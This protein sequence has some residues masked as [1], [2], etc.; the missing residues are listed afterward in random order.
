MVIVEDHHQIPSAGVAKTCIDMYLYYGQCPGGK[1]MA[2]GSGTIIGCEDVNGT[3][4][5]TILT[6]ATLLRSSWESNA[7]E[8]D[9][10][11][12]VYLGD[13]KFFEGY[14]SSHDFHFNIATINV[15]SD[16]ALPTTSL[17]PLDDNIPMFPCETT[18]LQSQRHLDSFKIRPGDVVVALGRFCG[19]ARLWYARGEF[20]QSRRPWIGMAL[21]N[22]YAAR[23]GKL[24][25]VISKFNI[26]EGVLVDEFYDVMWKKVG[27]SME[28]V[29][30]R[31]SSAAHLNLK[32]FVDQTSSDELNSLRLVFCTCS[33]VFCR[34]TV[35]GASLPVRMVHVSKLYK[36]MRQVVVVVQ[37]KPPKLLEEDNEEKE[38]EKEEEKEKEKE[39]K[40]EDR[41]K[42]KEKKKE[43]RE[44]EK[45]KEDRE[46]EGEGEGE[47]EEGEEGEEEEEE[48][49]GEE[50]E[51]EEEEKRRRRRRVLPREFEVSIRG[52]N[53]EEF[54][55]ASLYLYDT[56]YDLAVIRTRARGSPRLFCEF[57]CNSVLH[58][59][60]SLYSI[61]HPD[62]LAFSII[63]GDVGHP[64]RLK[65]EVHF[66]KKRIY[67]SK[68]PAPKKSS[69][70]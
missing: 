41:E 13:G 20:R 57:G 52:W 67:Y 61:A 55:D 37:S 34:F 53:D 62:R 29:V 36:K 19:S 2:T 10:K 25:K 46:K 70:I 27:K 66:L 17:R 1:L 31:E 64:K 22:L 58:F 14:V 44:K 48:E 8:D 69:F 56:N 5:S 26:S 45:E 21:S 50:E 16:V 4:I 7:I 40:K 49:E 38:K 30:M 63:R 35:F 33:L 47:G 28:V 11:V 60:M 18:L 9:I 6:S 51:E 32:V 24:E 43:D 12:K 59:G 23:I 65:E 68:Y 54:Q 42:E 39:K 3:Y 15:T